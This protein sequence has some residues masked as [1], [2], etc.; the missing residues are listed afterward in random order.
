MEI[1]ENIRG[2]QSRAEQEKKN[3]KQTKKELESFFLE[4]APTR[5]LRFPY[6]WPRQLL[7]L[8]LTFPLFQVLPTPFVCVCALAN[9]CCAQ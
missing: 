7:R 6:L 5:D 9:F 3:S 1:L 2:G 4:A 8:F